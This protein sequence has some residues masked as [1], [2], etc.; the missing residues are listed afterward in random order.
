MFQCC[1]IIV[2]LVIQGGVL[3]E[4][5]ADPF[6]SPDDAINHC[7]E[8]GVVADSSPESYSAN[9]LAKLL[10]A[11]DDEKDPPQIWACGANDYRRF[12]RF[13]LIGNPG[14][15]E[16]WSG[17]LLFQL[18]TAFWEQR[19]VVR[20]EAEQWVAEL[21]CVEP[22]DQKHTWVGE[23]K[24]TLYR[25]DAQGEPITRHAIL[26]V[27]G[28]CYKGG[29]IIDLCT[30]PA[31]REEFRDRALQA[32]RDKG[33]ECPPGYSVASYDVEFFAHSSGTR[34]CRTADGASGQ[35]YSLNMGVEL[36]CNPIVGEDW[37]L[38]VYVDARRR[39]D[40][41]SALSEAQAAGDL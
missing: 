24:V 35:Q 17:E 2:A 3:G 37:M 15:L 12:S 19:A 27:D 11:N 23:P 9:E 29:P 26:T 34:S 16:E 41:K 10:L 20:N 31:R 18:G 21:I 6:Q 30:N 1:I 32:L 22:C 33:V 5:R 38:E 4:L 7:I 40:E 39:C 25:S 14:P 36:T 8:L 28:P 13:F